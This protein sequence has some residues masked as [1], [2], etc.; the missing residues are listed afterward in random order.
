M[1]PRR[2]ESWRRHFS[3]PDISPSFGLFLVA[4]ARL[5]R[6]KFGINTNEDVDIRWCSWPGESR[7]P[8]PPPPNSHKIDANP[9]R[10]IPANKSVLVLK[11]SKNC[12]LF[13]INAHG[14]PAAA[15]SPF[16]PGNPALC[17]S[18]HPSNCRLGDLLCLYA[19][20]V[21]VCYFVCVYAYA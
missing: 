16:R 12:I 3:F 6:T 17:G 21:F 9:M 2:P 14:V 4:Y 1:S 11:L 8:D 15:Q 5:E 7:G 18:H 13:A 10:Q 20:A 19:Y